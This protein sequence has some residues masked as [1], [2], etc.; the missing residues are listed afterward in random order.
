[1]IEDLGAAS[2]V[3]PLAIH[4]YQMAGGL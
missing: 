4:Q 2:S 3:V 1:L